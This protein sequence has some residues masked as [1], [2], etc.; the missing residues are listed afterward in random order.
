MS[1]EFNEHTIIG[2]Y[3]C[4]ECGY[5]SNFTTERVREGCPICNPRPILELSDECIKEIQEKLEN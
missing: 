1:K 3:K 2:Q 5:T 4:K